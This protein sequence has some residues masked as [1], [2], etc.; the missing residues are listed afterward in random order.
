MRDA[1]GEL[2]ERLRPLCL[3]SAGLRG[4]PI[5]NLFPH[6]FLKAAVEL[7]KLLPRPDAFGNI[8]HDASEKAPAAARPFRNRKIKRY[9]RAILALTLYFTTDADDLRDAGPVI[10]CQV[11]IVL[12]AM[13]PRHQHLDVLSDDL[14]GLIAEDTL[15]GRVEGLDS[16]D[17]IN[18]D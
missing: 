16:T 13:Q 15:R 3:G 5:G 12:I 8:A 18:N 6:P 10:V 4:F 11:I 2:S 14:S 17:F 9:Q 1:A 7:F